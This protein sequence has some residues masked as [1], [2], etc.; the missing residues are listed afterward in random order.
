MT[1][2]CFWLRSVPEDRT[3]GP[4]KRGGKDFCHIRSKSLEA[5]RTPR[6]RLVV[7]LLAVVTAVVIVT[8]PDRHPTAMRPEAPPS[9]IRH[10]TPTAAPAPSAI[11]TASAPGAGGAVPLVAASPAAP[12][13][14]SLQGAKD[15]AAAFAVAFGSWRYDDAP[16]VLVERVRS[17]A[18]D[19]LLA[20]LG[21]SSSGASALR[22]R[23][24]PSNGLPRRRWRRSRPKGKG[25]ATSTCWR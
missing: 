2:S 25:R 1:N 3:G 10:S 23:W 14:G 9:S 8:Q 17:L 22:A 7:K 19:D 21:S 13:T 12:P 16:G 18:T 4:L 5:A 20:E 15:A 24:W 11:P 6:Q